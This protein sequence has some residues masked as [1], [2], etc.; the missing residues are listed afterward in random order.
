MNHATRCRR[1]FERVRRAMLLLALGAA[2]LCGAVATSL[3]Q[4]QEPERPYGVLRAPYP[5]FGLLLHPIG[6]PGQD[7]DP[8]HVRGRDGEAR[9]P[10]GKYYLMQWRVETTDAKGRRWLA[11]G[12]AWPEPIEVPPGGTVQLP[13]AAPLRPMLQGVESNGVMHFHLEYAGAHGERC[14]GITVD[15]EAPP[16]PVVWIYDAKGR[17]VGRTRFQKKCGGTCIASWPIPKG[18]T[19]RFRAVAEPQLGPMRLE[20]GQG[21]FFD[22]R[23][24]RVVHVPPA[25]GRPAPDFALTTAR[26]QTVQLGFLRT[27]PVLLCFFCNCGLC[28]AFAAEIARA[29]DLV[30]KTQIVV[31]ASD[32]AVVEEDDF[33]RATGLEAL[34]CHDA[35]PVVALRYASEECPRCW[36]I[37]TKGIVRYVNPERLMP[38]RKLVAD[39]RAALAPVTPARPK[40]AQGE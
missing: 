31:V 30:K 17:V 10:A 36:L 16:P 4:P 18:L 37:D 7:L 28:R 27:R 40:V 12:N 35:P 24:S 19:G 2:C 20:V 32:A 3:A 39:L 13:L 21:I 9:V 23:A 34:Y 11:R 15:G 8:E 1:R 5:E 25:I 22:L 6:E 29:K 14:R 33:R 26:G 38:A